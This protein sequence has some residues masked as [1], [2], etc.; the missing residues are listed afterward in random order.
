MNRRELLSLGILLG[1]P[2][3]AYSFIWAPA[4]RPPRWVPLFCYVAGK[5]FHQFEFDANR[6]PFYIATDSIIC[7]DDVNTRR[8]VVSIE[9]YS[10]KLKQGLR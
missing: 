1:V 9:E 6:M 7:A 8:V 10:R 2:R 5:E 4:S 3:H